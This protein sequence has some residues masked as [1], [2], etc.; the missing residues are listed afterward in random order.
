MS[1]RL[2]NTLSE[3]IPGLALRENVPFREVTSLGVG[4]LLPLLAEPADDIELSKLMAFASKNNIPVLN[5]GGG[6]N[7]AGMDALFD[8]IALRLR[9]GI[10]SEIRPGRTRH[11]TAGAAVRM[12]ELA[13]TAARSNLGGLVPLA[14]IPG[15]LGGAVRMNAGAN[16]CTISE[17]VV[18]LC[19]CHSDGTVWT[20]EK[21]D[22]QWNY[23]STTIPAD[24][25][26]TSVILQMDKADMDSELVLI[27]QENANR[28]AKEPKGRTAGCTFKNP[29]GSESA[30]RLIDMN[31]LKGLK[32]GMLEVSHEH[33]NYILNH[34]TATEAE[35]LTLMAEI[36][37]KV[38]AQTGIY[39]EPEIVFANPDALEK[40]H[41]AAP[42]PKVA[43]IMGG[44]SSERE[45]SL[46]S[47]AAVAL[48]LRN[49]GYRV[50]EI[51]LKKCEVTPEM[52]Q[53]DVI[54]S[55]LHGGFGEN[56]ELQKLLE[57]ENLAFVGSGSA[58]C[59]L[60][61]NKIATKE[62]LDKLA[63][64]TAK[65]A[66]ITPEKRT[67]PPHLKLPLVVKAPWEGST[68]GIGVVHS[69]D[70]W[71]K[72]LDKIFEYDTTLLAEEFV[73]GVEITVP[74]VADKILP[75]IEIR[76]PHGFYDYDAKYVYNCGRTQYF[77]PAE[78]V[79]PA[80]LKRA[81]E[82]ALKFY[83][84]SGC[85]DI[86]RVDFIVDSNDVPY[87][88]EGNSIPGCTATSLVPK[89]AKVAGISFE[90]M[91]AGL[92]QTALNRRK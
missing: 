60:V 56:G 29:G 45:V 81:G 85:R 50:T 59:E 90:M 46:R 80:A 54:Y 4:S 16:G 65:W 61:M 87:I 49:A 9:R 14:G 22:I 48:A 32:S 88:L 84:A 78:T 40:F 76:S 34:G 5:I 67:L 42:A 13:N 62:L 47:G 2:I 82:A 19:G 27:A 15:S 66:V 75:A 20:A 72:V 57:A 8:G 43:V 41:S 38:A 3:L 44:D 28:R 77:C 18:Q 64:P 10:F 37:K 69:A 36:R 68:V 55:L 6:S 24:V 63:L 25:I 73:N 31:G 92:V 26:I 58:A 23:R 1:N 86:L 52:R 39:L 33:A 74:I 12:A 89:A 91:T 51:D 21:D 17:F 53:A 83:H 79:S 11:L 30:G 7:L 70:E 35:L 71:D